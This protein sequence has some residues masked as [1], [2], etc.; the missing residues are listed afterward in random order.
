MSNNPKLDQSIKQVLE[1]LPV[2]VSDIQERPDYNQNPAF[3]DDIKH[4]NNFKQELLIANVA[5]SLSTSA[6]AELQNTAK[7]TILPMIENQI[8][9]NV[10]I[11]KMGQLNTNRTITPTLATKLNINLA[12]F[13]DE[14]QLL[15][16]YLSEALTPPP[17]EKGRLLRL[18]VSGAQKIDDN[19]YIADYA[20]VGNVVIR[21]VVEPNDPSVIESL[22]WEGGESGSTKDCRL[23]PL[24]RITRK[25]SPAVITAWLGDT[26]L[27]ISVTVRPL[28]GGL[29]VSN[30]IYNGERWIAQYSAD[31]EPVTVR[32]TMMPDIPD[33][34][35][36]LS[37]DGGNID[38]QHQNDRRLVPRNAVTQP[39]KPVAVSAKL[40]PQLE[41]QI[42]VV[43]QLTALTV[44]TGDGLANPTATEGNTSRYTIAYGNGNITVT[45]VTQPASVEAWAHIA[46][47]GNG[48]DGGQANIKTLPRNALTTFGQEGQTITATLGDTARTAII[49]V[50]PTLVSLAVSTVDGAVAATAT[51]GNTSDYAVNYADGN[52]TVTATTSPQE[53]AAWAY[54]A[55]TGDG[56]DG[57]QANIKTLP[58]NAL[59]TF[60]QAGKTI[61]AT[62]GDTARTAIIKV[63]PTLVSLAVSTL[64]GAVAATATIGNTSDYAVNYADGNITV[65]ATT[66]PQEQAAWAYIVWTG[67]GVDGGQANIKTLTRNT[68]TPFGQAG[69]SLTAT[70]NGAAL[71]AR[72][73]V[74]PTLNALTIPV[75]GFATGVGQ[76]WY[77]YQLN[78]PNTFNISDANPKAVA[79]AATTP[80]TAAAWAYIVWTDDGNL[81][82]VEAGSQARLRTVR[83]NAANT[84]NL[85]ATIGAQ[86]LQA[87]LA[88]R[89]PQQWP[90]NGAQLALN[91]I[92]FSGG[93]AVTID[94]ETGSTLANLRYSGHF[95]R[96]WYRANPGTAQQYPQ[97]V[98]Y[99]PPQTYTRN[100]PVGIAA[101][102]GITQAPNADA[103]NTPIRAT[104]FFRRPGG[105]ASQL[106]WQQNVDIPAAGGGPVVFPATNSANLPD[107]VLHEDQLLV[108]WEFRIGVGNW[109]LFDVSEHS[110]YVT[111]ADPIATER[112]TLNDPAAAGSA[113][114][115]WSMLDISC[116]AGKE[117]NDDAGA[118]IGIYT[119]FQPSDPN[120]KLRRKHDNVTFKYWNPRPGLAQHLTARTGGVVDPHLVIASGSGSCLS[121][122]QMLM[123]MFG[124]HG[125]AGARL[126]EVE[127]NPAVSPEAVRF[128]VR[129]WDFNQPP[130]P[131][132]TAY[133][134]NKRNDGTAPNP[135]AGWATW[136]AGAGQNSPN[137]PP[138]FINHFIVRLEQIGLD[139]FFDP[140]YGSV[141]VGNWQA[142]VNISIAG[143]ERSS[144]RQPPTK[145]YHFGT[146]PAPV[147]QTNAGFVKQNPN[148]APDHLVKL[149]YASNNTAIN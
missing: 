81:N 139:L 29:D 84:V 28:L 82:Q 96:T 77:S 11:T 32:A 25:D 57:G 105:N 24:D 31:G 69:R 104:A 48:V 4:L 10:A 60:G 52:I 130:P 18:E 145:W 46:W 100:T 95:P 149:R 68:L 35:R 119:A 53:Q 111:L 16:A 107:V 51:V 122:A 14:V 19:R 44:S 88:I 23:I 1:S 50:A 97:A 76:Q 132:G 85:T 118:A 120:N 106:S 137:P 92:T 67:D 66:S 87:Q 110:V 70:V 39:G 78:S 144:M 123:S 56:V 116:A 143:L 49:K 89:A 41:V 34:Y 73:K 109:V 15:V 59:T 62:L 141:P 102:I 17:P 74:V 38:P 128:L 98:L 112:N 75:Y 94:Y 101:Q 22:N 8:A 125:I 121:F 6:M 117:T 124:I 114:T 36:Y 127:S 142:W 12:S 54:I 2:V 65:T 115:L 79:Q 13:Q 135:P 90:G 146:A 58:R 33:A 80:D 55:W 30:A 3:A 71:I 37:W 91:N 140:S 72:I 21:A 131:S 63:V 147:P 40:N 93:R 113:Y 138:A 45:A 148:L 126:V 99:Q 64:D 7:N 47:T 134:H 27:Q 108:F 43:P 103:N 136:T 129:N 133:T 5:P 86:Q 42:E 61:T 9:A 20:P 26:R 83:L